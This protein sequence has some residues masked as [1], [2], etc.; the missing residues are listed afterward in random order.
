MYYYSLLNNVYYNNGN[1]K[2]ICIQPIEE[3][4]NVSTIHFSYKKKLIFN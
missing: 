1:K 4:M 2:G 3:I